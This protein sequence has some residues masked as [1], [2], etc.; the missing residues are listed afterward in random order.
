MRDLKEQLNNLRNKIKIEFTFSISKY[1]ENKI[2]NISKYDSGK[3]FPKINSIFRKKETAQIETL[4]VNPNSSILTDAEIDMNQLRNDNNGKILISTL[5][6]K[7][8]AIGAHFASIN[9][10]CRDNNRPRL[11]ERVEKKTNEFK[12]QLKEDENNDTTL[13]IFDN[14]NTA[15]EPKR[16]E[17]REFFTNPYDMWRRFKKINNKKSYGLD[18]IPN[19]ILKHVPGKLIYN[20][21]IIFNNLINY[22]I[23]PEKWKIAKV[24]PILKKNKDKHSPESYRPISMLPNIS[25]VY[26]SVINDRIMFICNKKTLFQKTNSDSEEIIQR[27]MRSMDWFP[28]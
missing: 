1:W 13:C 11:N 16:T 15:D 9:N 3:M 7:L 14:E 17:Y 19:I 25:K 21:T 5:Q 2:K 6:D 12:E 27:Y 8:D 23:F 10:N 28:M 22:A 18:G 24:I 20:Y 4:T 26:E